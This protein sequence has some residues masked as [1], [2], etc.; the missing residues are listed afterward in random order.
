MGGGCKKPLRD[1][2][3]HIRDDGEDKADFALKTLFPTQKNIISR[4]VC[5]M[6]NEVQEKIVWHI[7]WNFL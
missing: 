1:A 3:L 7:F 6:E 4:R 5:M 2:E